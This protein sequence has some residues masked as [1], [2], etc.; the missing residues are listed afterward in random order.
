MFAHISPCHINPAVT[1]GFLIWGQMKWKT[2]LVYIFA[3]YTGALA[4]YGVLYVSI[5]S[6][7]NLHTIKAKSWQ[8]SI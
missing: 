7:Y 3:Q 6:K 2:V 5:Y 4:G 1:L 8:Q